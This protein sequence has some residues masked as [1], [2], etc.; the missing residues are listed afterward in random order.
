MHRVAGAFGDYAAQ[1]RAA[2][3][4]EIADEVE[5]FVPAR[6]VRE[7]QP[8][9]IQYF[10]GGKANG[11]IKRGAADET[12]IAHGVQF[13]F[14]AERAGRGD[15]GGVIFRGQIDFHGLAADQVMREVDVAVQGEVVSGKEG[16]AFI[17][18][19]VRN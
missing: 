18:V 19:N 8:T 16:D 11:V 14:K 2:D 7:S 9:Y 3:E 4:G 6:L 12:H 13:V 10:I 5:D 17:A 15:L 1:Q